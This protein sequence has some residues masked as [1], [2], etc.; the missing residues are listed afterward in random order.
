MLFLNRFALNFNRIL[1]CCLNRCFPNFCCHSI[2]RKHSYFYLSISAIDVGLCLIF[3]YR[4]CK[5][6]LLSKVWRLC[7][8]RENGVM[9]S[10]MPSI[11]LEPSQSVLS[12]PTP[13]PRLFGSKHMD[14]EL[15]NLLKKIWDSGTYLNT[16][17]VLRKYC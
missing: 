7:R 16:N 8:S 13:T 14:S 2:S 9:N 10:Y 3:C 11:Q 6:F 5:T 15:N 1:H 17:L 12:P 4:K